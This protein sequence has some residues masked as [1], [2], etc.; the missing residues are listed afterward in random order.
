M[1]TNKNSTSTNKTEKNAPPVYDKS[2]TDF[3]LKIMNIKKLNK[4][5]G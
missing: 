5:F 4:Y 1:N 2:A 3:Y